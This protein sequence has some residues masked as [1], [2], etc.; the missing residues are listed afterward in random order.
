MNGNGTREPACWASPLIAGYKRG[1]LC[2][3]PFGATVTTLLVI[4]TEHLGYQ[5]LV[6]TYAMQGSVLLST[7]WLL[8]R[9]L[10]RSVLLRHHGPTS[11][12]RPDAQQML[13]VTAST[14]IRA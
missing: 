7:A 14:V 3:L 13:A 8:V 6:A 12:L 9:R 11:N 1:I 2:R 10:L 5:R 4:S